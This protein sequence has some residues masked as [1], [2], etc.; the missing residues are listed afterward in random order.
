MAQS[1]PM[2]HPT[3]MVSGCPW[4]SRG[5]VWESGVVCATPSL[6]DDTCVLLQ[7][8]RPGPGPRSPL[9][10]GSSCPSTELRPAAAEGERAV[11]P[12]PRQRPG[13]TGGAPL[14]RACTPP[15]LS[16]GRSLL[17]LAVKVWVH[18]SVPVFVLALSISQVRGL[19]GLGSGSWFYPHLSPF[20]R[21]PSPLLL[22]APLS[23][24]P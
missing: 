6:P 12:R 13:P 11:G 17:W 20:C 21:H 2:N 14:L 9:L 5:S 7:M 15:G 16:A 18:L 10:L 3:A 23:F 4:M 22:P 19:R 8:T 24:C 1:L